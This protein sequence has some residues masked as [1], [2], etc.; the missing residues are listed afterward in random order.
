[1]YTVYPQKSPISTKEP[2]VS[3]KEPYIST[4]EP[5]IAVFRAK[6]LKVSLA[7]ALHE[8][9]REGESVEERERE[10]EGESES[11]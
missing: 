3:T 10:T 11:S 1:L 9:V 6:G 8:C 7:I 4:K 5:Y 2:C